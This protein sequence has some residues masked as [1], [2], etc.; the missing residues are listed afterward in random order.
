VWWG[1]GGS[2]Q[3]YIVTKWVSKLASVLCHAEMYVGVKS[4][5]F[6]VIIHDEW[7][8]VYLEPNLIN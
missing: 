4:Y 5:S 2:S 6:L 3:E 8:V 1:G 7:L